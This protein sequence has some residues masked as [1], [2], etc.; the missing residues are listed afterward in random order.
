MVE[1]EDVTRVY[2]RGE[3]QVD[4]LRGVTATIQKESFNFIVGPSGSGK[5][6]LLYLIGALDKPSSGDIRVDGMSLN[7][8]S[9]KDRD[10]YRRQ[11]VGFIFQSF[12]LLG[13]LSAVDNV[14]VPFMPTGVS[15]AL[16]DEAIDLLKRVGLGDR[17]THRPNH[18][19]GGEQ[20]RVAIARA[21]LKK[22]QLVLADEPTGELDSKTGAEVFG[23]LRQLHEEHKTTVIV[24]THDQSYL[25]D[26]DCILRL[27]DGR[28]AEPEAT[29]TTT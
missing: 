8:F 16:K 6:S 2:L 18:L 29:A 21:L 5:S 9:L 23:Y 10:A 19:S 28:V 12:N 4:A 7:Q 24:V 14:L 13:N 15:A 22:P 11:Q 17:L 3:T 27:K 20:Q 26:S 25:T 1:I